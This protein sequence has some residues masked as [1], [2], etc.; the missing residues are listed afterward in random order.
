VPCVVE[1]SRL[2]AAQ[3]LYAGAVGHDGAQA[4]VKAGFTPLLFR[5]LRAECANASHASSVIAA[6]ASRV[7]SQLRV[8]VALISGAD[9][10]AA[11]DACLGTDGGV[12]S[13]DV[14][15]AVLERFMLG[16]GASVQGVL[17]LALGALLPLA[18]APSFKDVCARHPT[19]VDTLVGL[20]N[21]DT[22]FKQA[23]AHAVAED[24]GSTAKGSV[25]V[26]TEAVGCIMVRLRHPFCAFSP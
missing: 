11:V 15:A 21:P 5:Q 14:L 10:A 18:L 8:L 26:T 3:C 13:V 17:S 23:S 20:A 19:L 7:T 4:A 16:S 9:N 25:E 1:E 6:V 24:S 2:L 12:E 22:W